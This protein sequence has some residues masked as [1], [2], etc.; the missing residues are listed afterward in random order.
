VGG[1]LRR[2]RHRRAAAPA[3]RPE[4]HAGHVNYDLAQSLLAVIS[5]PEFDDPELLAARHADHQHIDRVLVARVGAEDTELEALSGPRGP[6]DQ[7]ALV[8][9]LHMHEDPDDP[10]PARPR[11]HAP[12]A[13][14]TRQA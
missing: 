6:T 12:E 4:R 11:G 3:P 14:R 7:Y 1:R 9:E 13:H 2:R 10:D 5:E 8:H